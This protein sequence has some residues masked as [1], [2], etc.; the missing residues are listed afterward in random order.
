MVQQLKRMNDLMVVTG[1]QPRLDG[2]PIKNLK[3]H[4]VI[5]IYYM[6]I[7]ARVMSG[8]GCLCHLDHWRKGRAGNEWYSLK[9]A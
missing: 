4:Y 5:D 3:S 8:D 7:G 9:A 2:H 1:K 6:L